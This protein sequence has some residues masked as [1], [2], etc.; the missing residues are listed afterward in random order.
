MAFYT[1]LDEDRFDNSPATAGPWSAE[2]QH[3]GPPSALLGRAIERFEPREGHRL[4][5]VSVDILGAVPVEPA[6][7][8]LGQDRGMALPS[9]SSS[10]S[11]GSWYAGATLLIASPMLW[12]RRALVEPRIPGGLPAT[13]TTC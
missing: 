13:M 5:R 9:M 10:S 3:A 6:P 12:M 1:Q 4:G 11:S 7:R 8:R 2:S